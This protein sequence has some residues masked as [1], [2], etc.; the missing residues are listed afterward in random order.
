MSVS[1]VPFSLKRPELMACSTV[2]LS[3]N[4]RIILSIVA[5]PQPPGHAPTAL[6]ASHPSH[7]VLPSD[8]TPFGRNDVTVWNLVASLLSFFTSS[9]F[10]TTTALC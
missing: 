5:S 7:P 2:P 9:C 1:P 3:Q 6:P 10:P 8:M 4:S